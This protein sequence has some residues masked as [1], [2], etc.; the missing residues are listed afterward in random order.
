MSSMHVKAGAGR[1]RSPTLVRL[2]LEEATSRGSRTSKHQINRQLCRIL[3]IAYVVAIEQL[4][5]IPL[6]PPVLSRQDTT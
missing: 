6:C 3:C 1:L 4:R 5:A 2:A